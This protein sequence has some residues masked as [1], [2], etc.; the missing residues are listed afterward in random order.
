MPDNSSKDTELSFSKSKPYKGGGG[1][2][3]SDIGSNGPTRKGKLFVK[4]SLD[5]SP[6]PE[7]VVHDASANNSKKRNTRPDGLKVS[8]RPSIRK[9]MLAVENEDLIQDLDQLHE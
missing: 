1:R 9:S 2:E 4:S 6:M 5:N 8:V 3:V 7:I